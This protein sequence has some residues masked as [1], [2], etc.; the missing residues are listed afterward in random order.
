[1]FIAASQISAF[2]TEVVKRQAA[3][4]GSFQSRP[5]TF[6]PQLTYAILQTLRS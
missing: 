1:M 3:V 5:H 4:T 2:P 6:L